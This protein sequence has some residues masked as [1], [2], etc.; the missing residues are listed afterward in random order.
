MCTNQYGDNSIQLWLLS[1]L[2]LYFHS[3]SWFLILLDPEPSTLLHWDSLL[4]F[5]H[6]VSDPDV[7]PKLSIP[8]CI[9][10]SGP[11]CLQTR[12]K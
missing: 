6:Q 10:A 1:S 5:I 7:S 8:V 9:K 4:A 3:N 12:L 11:Q 2:L